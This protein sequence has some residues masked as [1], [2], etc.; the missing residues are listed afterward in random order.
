M[1]DEAVSYAKDA[2]LW[3]TRARARLAVTG[4]ETVWEGPP[5]H[6]WP[7]WPITDAVDAAVTRQVWAQVAIQ[8][9]KE[10]RELYDPP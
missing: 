6:R 5:L 3:E 9:D 2:V 7:A 1:P 4:S 10:L 8:L